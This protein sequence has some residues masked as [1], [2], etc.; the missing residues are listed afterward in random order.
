MVLL[1][2]FGAIT[3]T[4]VLP[5]ESIDAVAGKEFT[6]R[7]TSSP[8]TG[9]VWE[10]QAL[11]EGVELLGSDYEKPSG[12]VRPGDPATRVFRLRALRAGKYSL[13]FQLKRKWEKQ[14]IESKTV[15]ANVE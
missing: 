6:V 2:C 12:D 4:M 15:T 10:V 1:I 8:S 5:S 13:T 7:L 3:I 9:Y 14:A 11:P